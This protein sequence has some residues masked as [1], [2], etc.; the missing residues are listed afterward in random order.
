[1]KWTVTLNEITVLYCTQVWI[2]SRHS[3]FHST[4]FL[5]EIARFTSETN[6]TEVITA[7]REAKKERKKCRCVSA[8]K[9]SK[10]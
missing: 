4:R 7:L 3:I 1:M 8:I 10:E 6:R 2:A 9:K 5:E